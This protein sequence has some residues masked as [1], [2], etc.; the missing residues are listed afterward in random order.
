M[1]LRK[2]KTPGIKPGVDCKNWEKRSVTAA[3]AA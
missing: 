2:I 3:G 1:I